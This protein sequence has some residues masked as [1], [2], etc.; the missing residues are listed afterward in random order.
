MFNMKKSKLHRLIIILYGAG[1]I[2]AFVGIGN[3]FGSYIDWLGQHS[4][5]PDVF[6]QNFYE[7][8]KL[9]PNFVF[10][11]GGG[12]NVY[13]FAYYG[14]LSP[15]FLISYLLPFADMTVYVVCMSI[16]LY[17]ASG[18]LMYQFAKNHFSENKSLFMALVF[19]SVSPI[20]L[21]YHRHIMYVW[22]IPF[23]ILAF[24]GLDRYFEKKKAALFV[25]SAVCIILTNYY[26]SVG[27]LV[28]L[29]IYAVYRILM[30]E[31][32]GV[33]KFVLKFAGTAGLFIVPVLMCAFL[34][35]PT[36]YT[37][38]ANSRPYHIAITEKMLIVPQ[39]KL[40]FYDIHSYGITLTMFIAILGNLSCKNLKRCDK[41]LN[42]VL[43]V[44]TLSPLVPFLLNGMLYIRSKV[45]IPFVILYL[46]NFVKFFGRLEKKET[47][48]KIPLILVGAYI[49]ITYFVNR[50]SYQLIDRIWYYLAAIELVL[51]V[52]LYKKPQKI[53]VLTAVIMFITIAGGNFDN[54]YV[55]IDD[56]KT[57]YIDEINELMEKTD[58]ESIYRTNVAYREE[59]NCNRTYGENFY[60]TS[61]YSSTPNKLYLD[62]YEKYMGNNE[63]EINS[64]LIA[65]AKNEMFYNFMGIRYDFAERDPG[66]FYEKV[67]DGGKVDLYENKSAYPI[68]YKSKRFMSE[69]N[70]DKLKFP[71]TAEVLM[72]H[73]VADGDYADKYETVIEKHNVVDSYKFTAEDCPEYNKEEDVLRYNIELGEEFRNKTVYLSF[74]VH[75]EGEFKNT[76]HLKITLN[77]ICNTLSYKWDYH[78]ENNK[79]DYVIQMEDTTTLEVVVSK[80]KYYISDVELYTSDPICEEYESAD[81]IQFNKKDDTI[82]CNIEGKTGEYLVTSIPY[83]KGFTAE[84]NG[85]EAEVEL[86]NKAF[87]GIKLKDGKNDIVIKFRSP[88]QNIGFIISIFGIMAF[89]FV[90][91][92]DKV[93]NMI[94]KYKE[95][96]MY[97]VFG[98]LTTVVSLATYYI[99]TTTFLNPD[100]PVELQMA[101]IISW[102]FSVSFAY[103]TNKIFVFKSHGNVVREI[104][105]FFSSRGGTLVCEMI[106]MYLLVT[107]MRLPDLPVK[108]V[109]QFI[110]IVANYV[111]SKLIVFKGDDNK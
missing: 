80:G 45:M 23:L 69:E 50:G 91:L 46:Y 37:L 102:I 86:V 41:F 74:Y 103:I 34:L 40:V 17:I 81:N 85:E 26:F 30:D 56:Y 31:E 77:G 27:C 68:A 75:N 16:I 4:V 51:F 84:I 7:T 8:G 6:R 98:V 99:C 66:F 87:V 105:K 78:N 108:I 57:L 59:F 25:L 64:I 13:N 79:F 107:A 110:V 9:I 58:G 15:L 10:D 100:K 63:Q 22:Y 28:S 1:I 20:L 90:L 19:M 60:G 32:R 65:G 76:E 36:A 71:Y 61:V 14:F 111:L 42:I 95:I 62:F 70:F 21:Q 97:L 11:L 88:W 96:I 94:K 43:L 29:F 55:K 109:V 48:L 18:L 44:M 89:I 83:D 72:T 24:I 2:A 38:M 82:S 53:L 93:M 39:M 104:L 101:N 67:A 12:Q 35:L 52:L 73:T 106:L 49:V 3:I 92:K 33:K 5:F 47:R 54:H